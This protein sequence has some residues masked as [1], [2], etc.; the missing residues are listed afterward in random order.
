MTKLF[1]TTALMLAVCGFASAETIELVDGDVI[2]APIT[3]RDAASVTVNHPSL[4]EMTI[5]RD[6]ITAIHEDV[7][8][9]AEAQAEQEA[10]EAADALAAERAADEGMFGTGLFKGWNRQISL[11][12]NGAEGNSQNINIR[13][14]FHTDY[15]DDTDRWIFDMLYRVSRSNGSTTENRFQAE[16][17]KDWL[18]PDEDYFF[19]ANAKFE[20]DDFEVWD[21]RISGFVGVG[22]QFVDNDK[23]NVRG[24]AGIGGNQTNGGGT[25]EFTVEALLGVEVDYTIS[26]SQSVQFTNYLYPSLEDAAD[27]RNITTLAWQIEIDKDKG[28]S[29]QLGVANEHDSAAPAGFKKNDF[30]YYAALVWDF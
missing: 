6:R 18:L 9:H 5:S 30:T 28:M 11:G 23:W 29:L 19:W 12:I 26:D 22:Y 14:N 17:I 16:L 1:T 7:D 3:A 8:A 10:A 25:N 4:G 27:F 2:N 15:E 24:R 20:W 21:N 13:G